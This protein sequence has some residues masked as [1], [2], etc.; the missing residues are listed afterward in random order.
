MKPSQTNG[1]TI[2]PFLPFGP[3]AGGGIFDLS[4]TAIVYRATRRLR[5][6]LGQTQAPCG[7]C[8]QFGIC[9]SDGPVNPAGCEY[10]EDWLGNLK[11]GWNAEALEKMRPPPPPPPVL[12]AIME[13]G[14]EEVQEEYADEEGL[15]RMVDEEDELMEDEKS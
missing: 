12:D 15:E 8:P 13:E 2:T 5:L 1:N 11:G 9:E 6:D 4:D 7:K 3:G 14:L 10:F